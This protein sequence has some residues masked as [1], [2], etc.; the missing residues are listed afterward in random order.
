M[1]SEILL[2]KNN[3]LQSMVSAISDTKVQ[4]LV[5]DGLI[6]PDPSR[7]TMQVKHGFLNK[8]VRFIRNSSWNPQITDMIYALQNKS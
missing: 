1:S 8:E 6:S 2:I 7:W 3:V 5:D 4:N